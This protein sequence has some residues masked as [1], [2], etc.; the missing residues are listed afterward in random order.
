MTAVSAAAA[1]VPA[2]A[3]PSRSQT[4]DNHSDWRH[5]ADHRI[6]AVGVDIEGGLKVP[7]TSLDNARM[8]PWEVVT[9]KRL[10]MTVQRDAKKGKDDTCMTAPLVDDDLKALGSR[11]RYLPGLDLFVSVAAAS[12]PRAQLHLDQSH[13]RWIAPPKR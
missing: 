13:Q 2:T 1:T 5:V 9:L 6:G 8:A 11:L 12:V 7:R 4:D 10:H 3:A